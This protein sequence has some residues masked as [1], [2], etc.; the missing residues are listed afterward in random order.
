M[1]DFEVPADLMFNRAAIEAPT[2]YAEEAGAASWLYLC[3]PEFA[4]MENGM[5]Y[6]QVQGAVAHAANVIS[7]PP[8]DLDV[9]LA[10]QHVEA[11]DRLP[12]PTLVTCRVGPR[13]SAVVYLYAGLQAGATAE[14][15]LA[16]AD[17][18]EAPFVTFDDYRAFVSDALDALR[19][20]DHG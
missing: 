17:A 7:D 9:D 19:P 6:E 18:D 15:V 3:G 10:R 11:L 16:R 1:A 8:R 14:E 2:A 4:D 5:S 13:A 20:A 12:R